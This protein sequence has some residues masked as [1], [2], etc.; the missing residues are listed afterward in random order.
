MTTPT[1]FGYYD[2]VEAFAQPGCAICR[3]LERDVSRFLETL[4]YEHPVDPISQ[5]NFRASRGLC[6]QHTWALPDHNSVLPTAILYNAVI[7]ELLRISTE[8]A[9]NRSQRRLI[10][11]TDNALAAA[12]EPDRP[13]PACQV[14]ERAEAIYVEVLGKHVTD[15]RL[16]AAFTQSDALCLPHFQ[17][18]LRATRNSNS[19]RLIA[20]VQRVQWQSL[21]GE[22]ELLLHKLDAHYHQPIGAESTSWLRALARVVGERDMG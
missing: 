19:A 22:L 4:L 16:Q 9:P 11:S 12:L 14:R 18:V 20:D 13:C 7:D 1:P 10:G 6:H 15:E 21:K 2:L 8:T 3:L 17:A 5:N